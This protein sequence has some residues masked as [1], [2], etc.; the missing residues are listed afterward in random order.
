ME[1]WKSPEFWEIVRDIVIA[2]VSAVLIIL[3]YD[4]KVIKP[5]EQVQYPTKKV[6]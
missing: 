6:R 4:H 5:R 3:G 1:F 2:V